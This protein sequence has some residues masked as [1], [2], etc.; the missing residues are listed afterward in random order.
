MKYRKIIL[1]GALASALACSSIM[2]YAGPQQQP[3]QP[4][5][6]QNIAQLKP[7]QRVKV[8]QIE[9]QFKQKT[10]EWRKQLHAERIRLNGQIVQ[11]G[12]KYKQLRP[13]VKRISELRGKVMM[14]RTYAQLKAFKVTGVLVPIGHPHHR[15]HPPANPT[16]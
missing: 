2:V 3:G 16:Q 12:T 1:S 5:Q 13:L 10:S 9:M 8:K 4:P 7:S 6:I 15:P 11:P 14:A